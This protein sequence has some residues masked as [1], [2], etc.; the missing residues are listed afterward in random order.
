MLNVEEGVA[1]LLM[2]RQIAPPNLERLMKS[3]RHNVGRL[4]RG[5]LPR[6]QRRKARA[7]IQLRAAVQHH[8]ATGHRHPSRRFDRDLETVR[9]GDGHRHHERGVSDRID[10]KH[11]G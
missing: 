8:G 4:R 11:R 5:D 1:E 2:P 9:M 7:T 3:P 6:L 10:L